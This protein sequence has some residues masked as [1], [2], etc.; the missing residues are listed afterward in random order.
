MYS[1]PVCHIGLSD[2]AFA[3]YLEEDSSILVIAR[4]ERLLGYELYIVEQWACSRTDPTFIITTFTG[5][6]DQ[7]VSVDVLSVP[8]DEKEWSPQ[9]RVYLKAMCQYHARKKATPLGTLMVTNLSGFPSALTVIPVPNGDLKNYRENFIVSENL[10]RLGCSGRAG[11]SLTAPTGATRAKFD[12]LYRISELVPIAEA[13]IELVKLCQAA[14][15]LFTKLDPEYADGLLCDATEQAITDWWTECGTDYYN[16]E[17]S[18]GILG[19]TTVSSLLGM[20]LGAR[21][22]LNAYGAPVSKDAFNLKATKRGLAYF[23]KWQK[24]PKTRRLDRQTLER[25][26][27]V[28]SKAANSEGWAVPKAVRST[29][30]ELGG[31]GGEMVMGMVGSRDKGGI[32]EVET[33]DMNKFIAALSGERCKWLW[34]GKPRKNPSNDLFSSLTNEDDLIFSGDEYSTSMRTARRKEQLSEVNFPRSG[35]NQL[36]HLY[37]NPSGSQSSLDPSDRDQALRRGVL[38]SVTGRMHEARSGLGRFKDAVSLRGH[39]HKISRDDDIS[40]TQELPPEVESSTNQRVVRQL[41]SAKVNPATDARYLLNDDLQTSLREALFTSSDPKA[42]GDYTPN[43]ASNDA[44]ISHFSSELRHQTE[45]IMVAPRSTMTDSYR[46]SLV[47]EDT[48]PNEDES[49]L[50]DK[51]T[52]WTQL[53][54]SSIRSL[55]SLGKVGKISRHISTHS[56]HPRSMSFSIADDIISLSGVR[57]MKPYKNEASTIDALA[58]ECFQSFQLKHSADQLMELKIVAQTSAENEIKAIADLEIRLRRFHNELSSI[59]YRKQE[60]YNALQYATKDLLVEELASSSG[61]LKEIEVLGAKLEYELDA[62]LSKLEDV[63]D[64]VAEFERQVSDLEERAGSLEDREVNETPWYRKMLVFLI[65][66]K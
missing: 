26:H 53:R 1:I 3:R 11:L 35:H 40:F 63:E 52:D 39:H 42:S 61:A 38:K 5:H 47:E 55:R 9:L 41:V 27:R 29:V 10:K 33:F 56:R 19:P 46:H 45:D 58:E 22:R 66:L 12:Q 20:F 48:R 23:Q 37:A 13:A 51:R 2:H 49:S 24:L 6:V 18:D 28:T 54:A 65:G 8:T 30:A 50:L 59:Y 14:L 4:G 57:I 25:L 16:T 32:S 7:G 62:L 21:N 17:A 15:V 36:E 34:Y 43:L 44:I 64:G 60:E 31:K